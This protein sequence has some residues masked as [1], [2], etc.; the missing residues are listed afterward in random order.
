MGD[1]TPQI[2]VQG[3]ESQR[4]HPG[5]T[6]DGRM[7]AVGVKRAEDA[8]FGE[9]LIAVDQFVAPLPFLCDSMKFSP[10]WMDEV[11]AQSPHI[12]LA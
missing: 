8:F 9:G 4:H 11:L 6:D 1:W 7:C 10:S 5:Q 3:T 12:R 2:V